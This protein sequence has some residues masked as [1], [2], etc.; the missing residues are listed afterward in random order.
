MVSLLFS[1]V[2]VPASCGVVI[3]HL[4]D[5]ANALNNMKS[6]W[7]KRDEGS[8]MFHDVSRIIFAFVLGHL[9]AC[10]R[11][12]KHS[13]LMSK[14]WKIEALYFLINLTITPNVVSLATTLSCHLSGTKPIQ[15]IV[16]GLL[17]LEIM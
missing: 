16:L 10:Q 17:S 5:E 13:T 7:E 14:I 1:S 4:A 3:H 12:A 15:P 9:S 8:Y 6:S 2:I 11:F